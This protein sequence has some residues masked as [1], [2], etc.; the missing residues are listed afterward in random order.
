LQQIKRASLASL[1][2]WAQGRSIASKAAQI[3]AGGLGFDVNPELLNPE[4]PNVYK[5]KLM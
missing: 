2:P 5:V 3:K 4:T 1:Q